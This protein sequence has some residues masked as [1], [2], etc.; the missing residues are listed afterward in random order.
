MSKH[1]KNISELG[2]FENPKIQDKFR[3]VSQLVSNFWGFKMSAIANVF[4]LLFCNF[5]TSLILTCS[6]LWQGSFPLVH[7]IKFTL[8]AGLYKQTQKTAV[9]VSELHHSYNFWLIFL[10]FSANSSNFISLRT[11]YISQTNDSVV[12][13][14]VREQVGQTVIS[15]VFSAESLQRGRKWVRKTKLLT[16]W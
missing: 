13:I 4:G 15:P 2:R 12:K 7:E 8:I 9:P 1:L 16:V 3:A 6:F 5:N 10:T 14:L 11:C